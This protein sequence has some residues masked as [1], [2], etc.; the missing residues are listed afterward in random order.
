MHRANIR[1]GPDWTNDRGSGVSPARAVRVMTYSFYT[2]NAWKASHD[3]SY[4]PLCPLGTDA[5]VDFSTVQPRGYSAPR[6]HRTQKYFKQTL[7][8]GIRRASP[9][10]VTVWTTLARQA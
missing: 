4:I 9:L 5:R 3:S 2:L 7:P 8:S 6:F 1:P 10:G